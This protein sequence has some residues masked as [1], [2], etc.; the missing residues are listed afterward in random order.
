M[1]CRKVRSY[2]SAYCSD[3]LGGRRKL[4]VGEHL[5]TCSTCRREEAAY[6]SVMAART[7]LPA[8]K[9]SDDFNTKLLN[10]IAQERFSETRTKAYLPRP[11]PVIAWGRVVPA[12]VSACLALA[13]GAVVYLPNHDGGSGPSATGG[14]ADDL[15]LTVQPV[16][17]PNMTAN[18]K[19]D[20]S[21]S[22]EMARAERI[23]LMT[24]RMTPAG[25][26][27]GLD[28]EARFVT[29][30]SRGTPPSPYA[31]R[32]YRV[33]PVVRVYRSTEDSSAKEGMNTY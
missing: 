17:N 25:N 28:N 14:R 31:D 22:K 5:S 27:G 4:A 6:R 15:Y 19:K 23:N 21:L 10:R 12:V 8:M 18:L 30:S 26:F 24:D 29:V 7:Q 13:I 3:E 32:C 20:W 1:R 9:L 11:A 2:L 16:N 33:R